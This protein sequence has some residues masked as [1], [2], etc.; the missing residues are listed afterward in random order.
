MCQQRYRRSTSICTTFL[1]TNG[2]RMNTSEPLS[3]FCDLRKKRLHQHS[4][5]WLKWHF[6]YFI[7][8]YLFCIFLCFMYIYILHFSLWADKCYFE[9]YCN[10]WS[11]NCISNDRVMS[12]QRA[13]F[14]TTS[15]ARFLPCLDCRVVSAVAAHY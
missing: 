13:G 2:D 11:F 8:H 9:S 10:V 14:G 6:L 12:D 15:I 5:K 4:F 7:L 3:Y 1:T